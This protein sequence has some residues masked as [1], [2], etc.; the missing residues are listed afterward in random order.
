MAQNLMLG[1]I[2][3]LLYAFTS[4]THSLLYDFRHVQTAC[5]SDTRTQCTEKEVQSNCED[6]VAVTSKDVTDSVKLNLNLRQ[7]HLVQAVCS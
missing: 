5:S 4:A 2:S 7:E 1:L 3:A 6:V